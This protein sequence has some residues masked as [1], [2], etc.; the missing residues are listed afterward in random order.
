[1]D[2]HVL[3]YPKAGRCRS[4]AKLRDDCSQLAFSTMPVHKHFGDT[5]AVIC[6]Q[7]QQKEKSENE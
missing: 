7:Y 2:S 3:Y 6:T 4:C 5:A 1:M